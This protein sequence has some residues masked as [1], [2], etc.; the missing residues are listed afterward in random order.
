MMQE[1]FI[2]DLTIRAGS[3][4]KTGDSTLE[5]LGSLTASD[6]TLKR[7]IPNVLPL[8]G[9]PI[10]KGKKFGCALNASACSAP[11]LVRRSS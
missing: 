6:V 3:W 10:T 5:A 4:E 11:T 9:L 7:A 1:I 8:S 2:R